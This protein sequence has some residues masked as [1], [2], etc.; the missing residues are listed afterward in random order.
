MCDLDVLEASSRQRQR[1]PVEWCVFPLLAIFFT[2]TDRLSSE[3]DAARSRSVTTVSLSEI[4]HL[5]APYVRRSQD[6]ALLLL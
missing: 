5:A 2:P 3:D 4:D 1:G 6:L